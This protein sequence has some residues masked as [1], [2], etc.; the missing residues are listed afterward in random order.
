MLLRARP[1]FFSFLPPPS[2]RGRWNFPSF[3]LLPVAKEQTQRYFI[4]FS[5]FSSFLFR[6]ADKITMRRT[7]PQLCTRG[8]RD[9]AG[10]HPRRHKDRP[11]RRVVLTLFSIRELMAISR[12]SSPPALS[13]LTHRRFWRGRLIPHAI[14]KQGKLRSLHRLVFFFPLPST[15][16][17]QSEEMAISF[18]ISTLLVSGDSFPCLFRCNGGGLATRWRAV[19]P[20]RRF[21]ASFFLFFFFFPSLIVRVSKFGHGRGAGELRA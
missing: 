14:T 6:Q 17:S 10:E 15:G 20:G 2:S 4:S 21:E 16:R 19:A 3:F 5:S 11:A 8:C 1:P 12:F 13:G 9:R 18:I 7:L